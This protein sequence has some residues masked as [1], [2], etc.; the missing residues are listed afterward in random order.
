[1]AK[2]VKIN[3]DEEWGRV[4]G[5]E[6]EIESWLMAELTE[7]FYAARRAKRSTN[8]EQKFEM[9][10]TEN[11]L[12]LRD[13]ILRG[14]YKPGSG[15][16][17]VIHD[18]VMREIFAAPFRDR[19]IHHFLYNGV[20]DWW[21][22]R[23]IEDCYSCRVG[24]G[25]L[26]GIKRMAKHIQA[27]SESYTKETY[28]VKMD[29]QGYFM[30]LPRQG[31]YERVCW[32]LDRQ[33]PNKGPK[34]KIYKYLW[35]EVIFDDPVLGVERRGNLKEWDILPKTKSLFAQPPGKGI[36]IGNLSS[37][38]LSNIYLDQL[39]R[40]VK[41]ELGYKHYGRY[42]DDF[43]IVVRKKDLARAK[44]D[45][46]L[47]AMFLTGLG[48]N[49]HPKKT[50]VQE[51]HKGTPFLGAVVYPGRVVPGKRVIQNYQRALLMTE[52]GYKEG[53]MDSVLSYMGMIKHLDGAKTQKRIFAKAGLDYQI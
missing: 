15:I 7:A 41:Y 36:V 52:S 34:Y 46:K 39:D 22:R 11:L 44:K 53:N 40:F 43:Y 3:Y 42:V 47:I 35:R 33:F 37:Q 19:V 17:F 5:P 50:H 48:L 12:Q 27:V 23:L 28:V 18:P 9:R 4:F 1:M 2:P 29:V 20:A 30:S 13:D 21:D 24:K 14:T 26:Y 31:L 51:I 32:G 8:D 6:E 49:L 10:L 45:V 25:T 38:L 16:A